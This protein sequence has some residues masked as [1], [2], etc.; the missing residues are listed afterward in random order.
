MIRESLYPYTW[1]NP[2]T[3]PNSTNEHFIQRLA[4]HFNVLLH[5]FNGFTEGY[6]YEH[7]FAVQCP[8]L[9]LRGETNLGAVMTDDEMAWLQ[10]NCS[11]V[12]RALIN[13]VGHLLHLENH[14]QRPVLT[15]M[16]TFL[17]NI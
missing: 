6:D 1:L 7:I 3:R 14:G 5:D 11:N 16:F 13:G 2:S 15:E 12:K 17:K 9:F 10:H 4:R 8:V